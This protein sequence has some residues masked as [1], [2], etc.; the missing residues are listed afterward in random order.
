MAYSLSLR[1]LLFLLALTELLT[2]CNAGSGAGA[3]DGGEG[4]GGSGATDNRRDPSTWVEETI[5]PEELPAEV[6]LTVV[7]Q[8][9]PAEQRPHLSVSLHLK[10]HANRRAYPGRSALSSL[11]I[12]SASD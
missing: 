1:K 4:D 3:P 2:A 12:G 8:A 10:H 9:Y 6:P 11:R 7:V 5:D